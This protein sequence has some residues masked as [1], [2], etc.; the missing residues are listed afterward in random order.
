MYTE[1][2]MNDIN[3]RIRKVWLALVPVLLVIAAA[4]IYALTA[5]VQWLALAAGPL[6]FVVACYGFLAHLWPNMRYRNFLRDMENGLS[7]EIRGTIIEVAETPQPQ[8][9]AMVLPVR[10][11]LAEEEGADRP[12]VGESAQAHRL[13]LEE[14][15]EDTRNERILYLNASKRDGLPAPGTVVT[16]RCFGRHIRAVEAQGQTERTA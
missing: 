13:R 1:R 10:L 7:R 8:D 11:R 9:G 6:L 15:G 12:A 4:Y 5:R 14:A 3:A 2:D 16:L